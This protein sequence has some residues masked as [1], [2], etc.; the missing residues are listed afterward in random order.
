MSED[1][2]ALVLASVREVAE[3][4]N[5]ETIK[6]PTLNTRLFG[7]NAPLDS[8]GLVNLVL[9]LEEKITAATGIS[10]TLASDKAMSQS[11]SPFRSVETLVRFCDAQLD[12][13]R[14]AA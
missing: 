11:H 1:M 8:M 4:F 5:L 9:A 6:N 7:H 12:A 10:L 13:M 2:T 14:K 3:I